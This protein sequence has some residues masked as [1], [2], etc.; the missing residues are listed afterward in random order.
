[1]YLICHRL[2]HIWSIKAINKISF[3]YAMIST[4]PYMLHSKVCF[5]MSF[6]PIRFLNG[7]D[8]L[9]MILIVVGKVPYMML[10]MVRNF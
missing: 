6:E 10:F 2:V 7:L 1:M 9:C 5:P 4:E 8:E 3:V